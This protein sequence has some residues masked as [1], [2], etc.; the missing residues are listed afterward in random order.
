MK[1]KRTIKL[2]QNESPSPPIALLV[3]Q[4]QNIATRMITEMTS[5]RCLSK[6]RPLRPY[7]PKGGKPVSELHIDVTDKSPDS[8]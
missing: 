4:E 6:V 2:N 5:E 1:H 3:P 7:E 8:S